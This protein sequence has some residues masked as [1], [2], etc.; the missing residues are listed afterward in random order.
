MTT[1]Q[2]PDYELE[3]AREYEEAE[4]QRQEFAENW[5]KY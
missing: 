5:G 2:E 3:A 4:D 1:K